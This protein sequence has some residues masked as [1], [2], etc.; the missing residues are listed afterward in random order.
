MCVVIEYWDTTFMDY[1]Q[2]KI[3]DSSQNKLNELINKLDELIFNDTHGIIARLHNET[4][5]ID[6]DAHAEIL[7]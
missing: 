4:N 6:G 5:L 3:S 1:N 7:C 2:T